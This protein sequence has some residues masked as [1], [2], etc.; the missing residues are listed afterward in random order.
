MRQL[1][2]LLRPVWALYW[3]MMRGLT[4]GVRAIV[5]DGNRV[6]LVRHG[7]TPG[8]H[9]PGGGVE[10]GETAHEAMVRETREETGVEVS[11]TARL[12]GI[13]HHP[14]LAGRDHVVVFQVT[15][16]CAGPVPEPSREITDVAWWPL[17]ALPPD[18]TMATRARLAELQ[19]GGLTSLTW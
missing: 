12:L 19:A 16:W 7:Y 18:T 10:P 5:L 15:A 13:Y 8:W 3:R 2:R 1:G 17:D 6:L 14:L 9:L 11:A 4:L